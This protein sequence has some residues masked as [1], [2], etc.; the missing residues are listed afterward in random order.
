MSKTKVCPECDG[1]GKSVYSCCGDVITNNDMD[2]CPTC[3]EH[4][5]DTSPNGE[6]AEDCGYCEGK[7]QVPIDEPIKME[8]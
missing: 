7:G 1:V 5:G 6:A 4:C 8:A 3:M 2:F